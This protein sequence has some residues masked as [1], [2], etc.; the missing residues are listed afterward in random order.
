MAG[1]CIR[2]HR[3]PTKSGR[4]VVFLTL[5]DETGLIDVTVFEDVY[6]RWGTDLFVK[7]LLLFGRVEHRDGAVSVTARRLEA[8]G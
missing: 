4:T 8:V 3:P 7:P 2:P 6:M 1:L 5:E